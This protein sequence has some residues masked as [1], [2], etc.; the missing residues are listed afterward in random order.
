MLWKG[1]S[2][3]FGIQ[4]EMSY[5]EP[6]SVCCEETLRLFAFFFFFTRLNFF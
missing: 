4:A 6:V 2:T 3:N 5:I 1:F